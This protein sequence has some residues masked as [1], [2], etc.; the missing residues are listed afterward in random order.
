M[1]GGGAAGAAEM[2]SVT[3][4]LTAAGTQPSCLVIEGELGIGKTTLWLAAIDR[5]RERGFQVLSAQT[6]QAE[7]MLAYAAAADLMADVDAAAMEQLP[8][9]Q[10]VALDRV[11]LRTDPGSLPTNHR[12]VGTALLSIVEG[13]ARTRSVLLAIDD[14][15]WLDPS[16]RAVV[17]FV[18]RRLTGRI[19]V[20]FTEQS[21]SGLAASTSWLRMRAPDGIDRI[22]L[23]PLILGEL[24]ELLDEKLSRTFSRPTMTQIAEL[25]GGNP[26]FAL[27]L[28]RTIA[29][30]PPD[31]DVALPA[32]LAEVVRNR[33]GRLDNDA[34]EMLLAAACAA[35]PTVDL[36]A[37]A[38]GNP[39]KRTVE[40]LE[41]SESHDIV[42]I[43][44][45]RVRFS[46]ALLSKGIYVDAN[47]SRRRAM[48]RVLADVEMLPEL[49]ARHLALATACADP[50]TLRALDEAAAAAG[51][52]GAP[53]AAAELIESA[54]RLGGDT[55]SRRLQAAEHYYHAGDNKKALALLEPTIGQLT[56]G[57]HRATALKLLAKILISDGRFE[58]AADLL[59]ST[60]ADA[61]DDH[62]LLVQILL[63]LAD[64]LV[65]TGQYAACLRHTRRAVVLADELDLPRLSCQALAMWVTV[66]CVCGQ[67][68]DKSALQRALELEI[69][70]ID[71]PYPPIASSA[72][73][74]VLGWTGRLDE[75]REQMR[76]VR[77]RCREHGAESLMPFVSLHSTLI[78]IWC[79]NFTI[80]GQLAEDAMERA[81][82][83]GGD[84]ALAIAHTLR[85]V[86]AAYTGCDSESRT[87]I[88]AAMAAAQQCGATGLMQ[89]PIAILGFLEV[90]L[91][92]YA[93][94]LVALQPL[95]ATFDAVPGT[96]IITASF[97]PDAVEAMVGIGRLDDAEPFIAALEHNGR[98][99]DRAW[100]QAV[101][102]RCRS[103]WLAARGDVE[104]AA[105]LAQ[106][107]LLAHER[108]PMPFERARTELLLGHLM[109]RKRDRELAA[110]ALH[111]A[112][113]TF[114]E[115][116]A[117]LWAKRTRRELNRIRVRPHDDLGLTAS[118]QQV[119][120][121]AASGMINR[122]VAAALFIS[123]KTVE[124]SLSS[125]Y[126]KLGIHSRAELGQRI[127]PINHEDSSFIRRRRPL[128]SGVRCAHASGSS[129]S[130]DRG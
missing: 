4:F 63:L 48:H 11:L 79:G 20:V 17:A 24:R 55:Q 108:L 40:L 1:H 19:G 53:I 35:Q 112:L 82:H 110:A 123:P 128:T 113:D 43:D 44:G 130:M 109:R 9:V 29:D 5:A 127:R 75:A 103:M 105:Q 73:A 7:S 16:S 102:A 27:E 65:N 13:L 68:I 26:Y 31:S 51:A 74:L 129:R 101:G 34:R 95:I 62:A 12:V 21:N 67:G 28:A 78:E 45:N 42:R 104:G 36:L 86:V 47:P 2:R 57:S 15:Q 22:R 77:R 100:M 118:E 91:G 64:A 61:A 125:T 50:A 126:R 25:S 41:E 88:Q 89:R 52:R 39:V 59:Q 93:E 14:V 111:R 98:R 46:H 120:E 60:L 119:A 23:R 30:E 72:S 114:D 97:L 54:I 81:E 96:E 33:I 58:K 3:S 71:A 76:D 115:I 84:Y 32:T 92:N 66:N 107:A 94:A 124:H 10:R 83:F 56:P 121:L 122:D 8:E 80:A 38:T 90:S 99:L 85:A 6:G 117:P 18:A 70:D 87:G 106:Q 49:K 69:H 37:R 116:G